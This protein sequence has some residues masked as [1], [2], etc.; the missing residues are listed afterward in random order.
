MIVLGLA[1]PARAGKDTIADYLCRCYG[2]VKFAFSDALYH[3]VQVAFDLPDQDLLRGDKTK[4]FPN[5]RLAMSWCRDP[6]FVRLMDRLYPEPQLA[7]SAR[8][9]LQH[10]GTEYRRAHNPDYWVE[11]AGEFLRDYSALAPYPEQR[12]QY[13]VECGTR[14]ENERTWIHAMGG[15]IWHVHRDAAIP[16][17]PHMSAVP[18]PVLEGEREIWNN[19]TPQ[20]LFAGIDKLLT[21]SF[22]FVRVEPM[23]TGPY[24]CEKAVALG[25]RT[26]PDCEAASKGYA[27]DQ[28]AQAEQYAKGH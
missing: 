26:C 14:F 20:R 10:W 21:T 3:E 28:Q 18:L 13:F 24:C 25:T 12:Q 6:D 15:N 22:K 9:I 7:F 8:Q 19:D 1:G 16:V 2:F 4:D 17:N 23:Y 27:E 11:K 5:P